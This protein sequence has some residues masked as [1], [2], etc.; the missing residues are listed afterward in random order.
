MHRFVVK[1][2]KNRV[3][4][5][6]VDDGERKTMGKHRKIDFVPKVDKCE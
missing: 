1:K 4:N 2:N 6:R 3:E 5:N